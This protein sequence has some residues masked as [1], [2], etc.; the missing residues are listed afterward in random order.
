MD[1]QVKLKVLQVLKEQRKRTT[2]SLKQGHQSLQTP[3]TLVQKQ[4]RALNIDCETQLCRTHF[5]HLPPVSPKSKGLTVQVIQLEN[6]EGVHE[7]YISSMLESKDQVKPG[8]LY[9]FKGS[10]DKSKK[11]GGGDFQVGGGVGLTKPD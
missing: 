2:R 6:V 1:Y 7:F 5:C 10:G 3:R 8:S 4:L 9:T 11:L